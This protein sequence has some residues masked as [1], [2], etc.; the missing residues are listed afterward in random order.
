[1]HTG[2]L[3]RHALKEKSQKH[4]QNSKKPKKT[5]I[6]FFNFLT[7]HF[8]LILQQTKQIFIKQ[9]L[10]AS[11]IKTASKNTKKIS[12]IQKHKNNS[13]IKIRL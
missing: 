2:A 1:M 12:K 8:P 10:A 6:T 5:L 9:Q 3:K 7:T 4:T 13:R 11:E